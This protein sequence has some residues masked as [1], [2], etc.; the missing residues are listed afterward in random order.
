MNV[1]VDRFKRKTASLGPKKKLSQDN[2]QLMWLR[3]DVYV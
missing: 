2:L 3:T 1:V